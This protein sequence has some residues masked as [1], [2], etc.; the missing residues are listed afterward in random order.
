MTLQAHSQWERDN[1]RHTLEEVIRKLEEALRLQRRLDRWHF[2]L[3]LRCKE[4]NV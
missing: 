4:S 3:L 1:A 2:E